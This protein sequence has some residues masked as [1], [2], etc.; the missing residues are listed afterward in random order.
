M[1]YKVRGGFFVHLGDQVYSPEDELDIT[2][3]QA[4]A[5]AHQIEPLEQSKK[6][7]SGAKVQS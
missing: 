2:P 4:A 5:I 7:K 3:E 6:E 1:K